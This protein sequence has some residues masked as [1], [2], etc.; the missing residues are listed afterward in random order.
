MIKV[1]IWYD[2]Y[3]KTRLVISEFILECNCDSNGSNSTSCDSHGM[4][5]CKPNFT[6][7]KCTECLSGFF[8]FPECKG[9]IKE[10]ILVKQFYGKISWFQKSVKF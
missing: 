1:K 10:L 7:S 3:S 8:G 6:G 2:T 5:T 9:K 4:C